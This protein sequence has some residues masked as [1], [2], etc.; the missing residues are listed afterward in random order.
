MTY[1]IVSH[2]RNIAICSLT[3][4]HYRFLISVL[5]DAPFCIYACTKESQQS[6][7]SI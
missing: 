5:K 6:M 4:S 2:H 7:T 3:I 1:S